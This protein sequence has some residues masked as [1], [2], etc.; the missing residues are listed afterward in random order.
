MTSIAQVRPIVEGPKPKVAVRPPAPRAR[1]KTRHLAAAVGF[2]VIAV[3]PVLV[4]AWYM[5]A[6][7][8]D[9][10]VSVAGFSVRSEEAASAFELLGGMAELSGAASKDSEVL[11]Q[12]IQSQDLVARID[13]QIDLRMLWSRVSYEDDPLFAYRPPGTIEDLTDHWQRMVHVYVDGGSGLIEVQVQAFTPEDALRINRA[14]YDESLAMINR[15]S[16]IAR[17]D[18]TRY[19]RDDFDSAMERLRRA[20]AALTEFRNRTQ[21]VDP[22]A[23]IQSQM[24]IMTSLQAALANELIEFDILVQSTGGDDPRIARAQDRIDVIEAR[25]Q[26]ERDKFGAGEAGIGTQRD[27]AFAD[28]VSAYEILAVDLEFA[29]TRY[30]AAQAALD[31]AL[32]DAGRQNRYLAAHIQPTLAQR[33]DAPDRIQL[34]LLVAVFSFLI[35]CVLTLSAY[36]IRDRR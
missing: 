36:A 12:F 30:R 1:I 22:A 8:A 34:T 32:A 28:L 16:A 17:E 9:R 20:R 11:F 7:A 14:I 25:I 24:G 29:E 27:I 3:A 35:W 21:I 13:A 2:L 18:T 33:S 23:S 4:T 19:A 26:A 15:L 6:H 5:W 10:Y 31:I